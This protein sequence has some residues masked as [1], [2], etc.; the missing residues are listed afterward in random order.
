MTAALTTLSYGET[1]SAE[2]E[3]FTQEDFENIKAKHEEYNRQRDRRYREILA[4]EKRR[5]TQSQRT[6]QRSPEELAQRKAKR[7][8]DEKLELS[9]AHE[10]Y[11]K[12]KDTGLSI[13]MLGE[14]KLLGFEKLSDLSSQLDDYV[15]SDGRYMPFTKSVNIRLPQEN[16]KDIEIVD[17]P[18]I[19]DPVQSR[20]ERTRAHLNQ[21]DVVLILSPA[22]QFMNETDQ[23]LMD[24]ITSKEGIR[25]LYVVA[26]Q[27]DTQLFGNLRDEN[28]GQLDRVLDSIT[29]ELGTHLRGVIAN[30]KKRNPEVEDTYDQLLQGKSQIIHSSGICESLRQL[31]E[32]KDKWDEL[33]QHVWSNLLVANYPD[34]FSDTDEDLSSINLDKL[35]NISAIQNIIEK[36]HAQKQE[37]INKKRMDYVYA[38]RRSLHA[39]KDGLLAYANER[40]SEIA[41]TDIKKI[42]KQREELA[43]ALDYASEDI[44]EG[45]EDSIYTITR[46]LEQELRGELKRIEREIHGEHQE[47]K[48]RGKK[49]KRLKKRG[50]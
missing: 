17:T 33:M 42:K 23:E 41:S 48:A 29:G 18:G 9:A 13:R 39:L 34:Y 5:M 7:E 36:V 14:S 21:C 22:G 46:S 26:A 24:R 11:V 40:H 3:F 15:G 43:K 12:M 31:F 30:L 25:E 32:Q 38:K 37:I 10:Q 16:L 8:M 35:S 1:P 45:Y 28:N 50:F 44:K 19:N 2:V 47:A 6:S 20:E 49:K 4:Q 27:A